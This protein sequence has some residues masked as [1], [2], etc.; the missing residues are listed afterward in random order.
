[1]IIMSSLAYDTISVKL[2]EILSHYIAD[3]EW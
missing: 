3:D 1:M 2:L